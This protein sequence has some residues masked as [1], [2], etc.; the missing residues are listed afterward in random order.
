MTQAAPTPISQPEREKLAIAAK[1]KDQRSDIL[2][3]AGSA[4]VAVGLGTIRIGF[5]L[6]AAGAFCL[7]PPVLE[8]ASGFLKGLRAPRA[9]G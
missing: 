9:R 5:G 2:Y 3:Y 7:L 8:L 4:L 6:I 1:R